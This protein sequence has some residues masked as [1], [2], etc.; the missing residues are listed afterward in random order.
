MSPDRAN[1]TQTGS[2]GVLLR[3]EGTYFP[4]MTGDVLDAIPLITRLLA[5][6]ETHLHTV[7][8]YTVHLLPA[9]AVLISREIVSDRI[10]WGW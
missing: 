7:C 10:R 1:R 2:R 6:T 3:P 5:N 8:L 9:F 4:I